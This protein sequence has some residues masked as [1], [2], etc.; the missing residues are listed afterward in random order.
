MMRVSACKHGSFVVVYLATVFSKDRGNK[1]H[2]D[3]VQALG[4][5]YLLNW[6]EGCPHNHKGPV[7]L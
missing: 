2:I 5:Q 1:V 6:F 4:N 3:M 7:K